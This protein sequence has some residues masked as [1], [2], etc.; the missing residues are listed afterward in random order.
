MNARMCVNT[1]YTVVCFVAGGLWGIGRLW[2]RKAKKCAGTV[3]RD[4][5]SA[6]IAWNT[7]DDQLHTDSSST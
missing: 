1:L 3:D 2:R 6:L 4:V 5:Q 7:T